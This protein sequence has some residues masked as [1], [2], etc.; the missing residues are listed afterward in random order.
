MHPAQYLRR[1]P[2]AAYLLDKC[3]H[4]S[5]STLAKLASLGG[6]PVFR[7]CGR[8]VIYDPADLDSWAQSKISGPVRSTSE[9]NA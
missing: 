6:G 8:L 2:A 5:P 4:G 7:K 9:R 3:G 1:K